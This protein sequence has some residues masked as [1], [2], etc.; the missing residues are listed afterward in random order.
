M[1]H[2]IE[3]NSPGSGYCETSTQSGSLLDAK[4]S[5]KMICGSSKHS[6]IAR[7]YEFC[8]IGKLRDQPFDD[9]FDGEYWMYVLN[10]TVIGTSETSTNYNSG[11]NPNLRALAAAVPHLNADSHGP[12]SFAIYTYE[13]CCD[14]DYVG[15][16]ICPAQEDVHATTVC[17]TQLH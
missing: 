10:G 11:D 17:Q 13:P 14:G 3:S 9:S 1:I 4:V 6:D 15:M 12:H 8:L 16:G 5:N 7:V 2:V